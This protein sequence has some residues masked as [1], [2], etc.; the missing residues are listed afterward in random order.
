MKKAIA[1][2][3]GWNGKGLAKKVK[4]TRTKAGK[5]I[6]LE[7]DV[8]N[9]PKPDRPAFLIKPGDLITVAQKLF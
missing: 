9:S 1:L 6:T 4:V 8:S 7:V 3:G 2:A 5:E